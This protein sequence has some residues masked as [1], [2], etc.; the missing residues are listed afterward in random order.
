MFYIPNPAATA[1]IKTDARLTPQSCRASR[2]GRLPLTTAADAWA[3]GVD[4]VPLY[5]RGSGGGG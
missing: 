3:P 5:T 1:T 2:V 4:A